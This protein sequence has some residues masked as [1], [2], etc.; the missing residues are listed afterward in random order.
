V[1]FGA[2]L[3]NDRHS[4]AFSLALTARGSR[5]LPS[6]RTARPKIPANGEALIIDV[7]DN[8]RGDGEMQTLISSY[9]FPE[10][11]HLNDLYERATITTVQFWTRAYV[12]GQKFL[13]KPEF[14]LTSN[15]AFSGGE[16][17]AYNLQML[18]RARTVGETTGGGA[19]PSWPLAINSKFR[20]MVPF[21]WVINLFRTR[22]LR[23]LAS[24]PTLRYQRPPL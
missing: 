7:R 13:N 2:L 6:T 20:I 5:S 11:V 19:N 21:A 18:G 1:R 3:G 12:P 22:T 4:K 15:R 16:S 23:E 9:L 8:R 10:S 14:V 17:F 24:N